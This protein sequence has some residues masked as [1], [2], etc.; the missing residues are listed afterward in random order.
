VHYEAEQSHKTNT[1]LDPGHLDEL[2]HPAGVDHVVTVHIQLNT[3]IT[4]TAPGYVTTI[5]PTG[6]KRAQLQAHDGQGE[7]DQSKLHEAPK[8]RR[9]TEP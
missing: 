3:I 8:Q 9:P 5:S 7:Q 6:A 1:I 4:K 2:A